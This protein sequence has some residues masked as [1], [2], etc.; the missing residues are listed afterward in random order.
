MFLLLKYFATYEF[1]DF[2]ETGKLKG[3][4]N[5]GVLQYLAPSNEDYIHDRNFILKLVRTYIPNVSTACTIFSSSSGQ[6][7]GQCVKPK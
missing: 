5:K 6:M 4:Q 2:S 7:S 3:L 1:A